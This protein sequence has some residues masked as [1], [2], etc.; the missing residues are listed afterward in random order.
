MTL[1]TRY[2]R[3]IRSGHIILRFAE[4]FVYTDVVL[5]NIPY[6]QCVGESE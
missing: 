3:Q 6:C 2:F 1:L 4:R 5:F